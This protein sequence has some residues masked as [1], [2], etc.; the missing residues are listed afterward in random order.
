M[1]KKTKMARKP[2]AE[3]IAIAQRINEARDNNPKPPLPEV[4]KMF[5]GISDKN[6]WAWKRLAKKANGEAKEEHFPLALIPEKPKSVPKPM[7]RNDDKD[8]AAT[9]LEV[10]ARLLRR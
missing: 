9:L 1:A 6:Y 5:P 2:I 4:L 8:L 3:R 10:A 7:K